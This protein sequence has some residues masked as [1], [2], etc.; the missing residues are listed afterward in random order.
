MK[1]LQ[2][3]A[4]DEFGTQFNGYFL[5]KQL[6]KLGHESHMAVAVSR[7]NEPTIHEVGR[8][9]AMKFINS[10][11]AGLEQ[12]LG[13]Q[14]VLPIAALSLY[15]QPYYQQADI[16][17][18]HLPHP[19]PFFSLL[20][21]PFMSRHKV[22]LW[23]NHD[24]WLLGGHCLYQMDCPGWLT[25]CG[26]CPDLE[27]PMPVIRD[28][29]SLNWR[30]KRWAFKDSRVYMLTASEWTRARV[31]ESPLFSHLPC[32]AI[33]YGVNTDIFKPQDQAAC[34]AAL[35]IP[36]E[37]KVVM[38]RTP[39]SGSKGFKGIEY[40]EEALAGM[41]PQEPTYLLTVDS[42]GSLQN[43][44]GKYHLVELGW[45]NDQTLMSTAYNAADIFLMPS[46]AEAFGLMAL[47][48]MACGTPLIV[49]DGTALPQVIK[50]PQGGLV[51]PQGDAQALA[52]AI[53]KL[54]SE[55][56]LVKELS[57]NG[58]RIIS[59]NYTEDLYINRHL[60]L[61]QKLLDERDKSS[62]KDE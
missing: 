33:P 43:L 8:G 5:H 22:V 55:P 45:T 27:R 37:A 10:R 15:R 25:G 28:S 20:N 40:I 2:I 48:S 53:E 34:R 38:F 17:H 13:L 46:T 31:R 6:N 54:F 14:S 7:L 41:Q 52:R 39:E 61:Y 57:E 26:N 9:W 11:L 29:T 56:G 3:T 12:R 47:E 35:G 30:I 18:L 23:T 42:K 44:Q 24:P 19:V 58:P 21:I 49:F 50:A 36:A 60:K 51:V 4:I 62:F 1:T 32:R 16:V 59:E